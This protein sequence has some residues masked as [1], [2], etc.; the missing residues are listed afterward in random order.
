M[1]PAVSMRSGIYELMLEGKMENTDITA[2]NLHP[3]DTGHGYM[4]D[5]IWT[6]FDFA[7]EDATE[8]EPKHT[9]PSP[10]TENSYAHSVRYKNKDEFAV[11]LNEGF[12]PD[13]REQK[14]VSDCFKGGWIS[15]DSG[16]RIV[17]NIVGSTFAAQYMRTIH[18]PAPIVKVYVDE[19]YENG[20]VLDASFD[21]DW[22]DKLSLT[23]IAKNLPYKAH[24]IEFE[25]VESF[26]EWDPDTEELY[27]KEGSPFM[28]V[29]VVAS[30]NKEREIIHLDPVCTHNIWGGTKLREDFG[31]DYEGDDLGEC[32][33]ISAHPNGDGVVKNG[34][35]KGMHLSELFKNHP[36]LFNNDGSEDRFPLLTKIIDARD[37]LSIQVHPDDTYAGEN[38]NGSLGKMECWYV[39]D[40]PENATL[41]AGHNAKSKDELVSM[42][43]EG[44]WNDFIREIP[45]KK[46][47]FI[48]IDPG[49]VHAIKGGILLLET[50]QNS[51]ITYRVYDYDR[52]QNGK[53]RELHVK[54]S[55]DVITVPAKSAE[56]S[57]LHFADT[58][59]DTLVKMYECKYYK[60]Y[61]ADVEK[62]LEIDLPADYVLLSVTEGEGAIDGDRIKKGDHMI[63]PNGYGKAVVTG[64]LQIILS[65][66]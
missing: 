66:K 24:K 58:K 23:T 27:T 26:I 22:G 4:A 20:V 52:L 2:D 16:D 42:I 61:K 36:E 14:E 1:L 32:W 33:G 7:E 40:A 6:V 15:G 13:T 64:D 3:N 50:Q 25:T 9:L 51:D 62:S 11:S 35:Y 10:L 41:V 5:V 30:D 59:K 17:F 63:L 39:L 31:Y 43:N 57:V 60:V 19:D 55:I 54:K 46:G 18:R 34:K 37:D 47:D 29:S 45:V 53:K 56:D 49:T 65:T 8:E 28:L 48:Q 38:E 12:L 44:R 21:E